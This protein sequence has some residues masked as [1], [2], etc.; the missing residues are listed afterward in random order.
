[1]GLL[2]PVNR[3]FSSIYIYSWDT[4]LLFGNLILP[5]KP[6]GRIVPEGHPGFEGKWPEHI[7]AKEGDSRCSCPA[8]NAMA[9]HGIISHD[10]RA[11]PFVEF[12]KKLE[13]TYNL[14]PTFCVFLS[15]YIAQYMKKD[16]SKDV[17]DLRDIDI[18]NKIEH[19][20]SLIRNDIHFEPD[21]SKIAADLIEELLGSASGRDADG[22]PF[23]T[24]SDLSK[25]FSQRQADSKANNPA[26]S[27]SL[28]L[29]M[30][31]YG[32]CAA[33]QT[34]FGGNVEHLRPFLL[35]EKL[36]DGWLPWNKTHFGQT[37][38]TFNI[39]SLR[40]GAG[41]KSVPPSKTAVPPSSS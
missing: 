14:A 37:L 34:V 32:N 15:K 23:L 39:A 36:M 7:P 4:F 11:I 10:G 30:F 6:A 5:N 20:G 29:R 17:F 16:F 41:T 33:M 31:A 40:I 24:Y 21:T 38:G 19:D 26:F 3:L 13:A 25:A 12:T 27:T 22:K 1:M 8:L 18:H 9:N 2:D 28:L 35:E